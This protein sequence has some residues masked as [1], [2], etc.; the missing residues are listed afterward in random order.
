MTYKQIRKREAALRRQV[1]TRMGAYMVSLVL[2]AA[3]AMGTAIQH[4]PT[5]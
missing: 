4:L 1:A 3:Y 5:R 2:L